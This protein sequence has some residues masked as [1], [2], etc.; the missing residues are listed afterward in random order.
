[1]HNVGIL[2]YLERACRAVNISRRIIHNMALRLLLMTMSSHHRAF[3]VRLL[4]VLLVCRTIGK[5][6]IILC[7]R[8]RFINKS[9]KVFILCINSHKSFLAIKIQQTSSPEDLAGQNENG[10]AAIVTN[11]SMERDYRN[12]HLKC[13]TF[14]LVCTA[15]L[16]LP[17][18]RVT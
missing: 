13:R 10:K 7:V 4:F 18:P 3:S 8:V 15:I 11:S 17:L 1:M 14:R 16:V 2:S 12:F 9:H 6:S 5:F